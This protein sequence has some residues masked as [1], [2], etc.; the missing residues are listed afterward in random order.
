MHLDH[1]GHHGEVRLVLR[2][3]EFIGIG[4]R[5]EM[6]PAQI[7]PEYQWAEGCVAPAYQ[8][9]PDPT[10]ELLAH[11]LMQLAHAMAD[12]LGITAA[13]R[14][15]RLGMLQHKPGKRFEQRFVYFYALLLT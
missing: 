14:M 1:P 8:L 7:L 6:Q 13:K 4:Q 10:G 2:H 15:S 12:E 11:Q 5:A 9:G 3:S